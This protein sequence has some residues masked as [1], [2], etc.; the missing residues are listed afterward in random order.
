MPV[1]V[2]EFYFNEGDVREKVHK[3]E[4]H[5]D[6]YSGCLQ[7]FQLQDSFFLYLHV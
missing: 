6:G 5:H 3:K 4:M 2:C 7:A 1:Y